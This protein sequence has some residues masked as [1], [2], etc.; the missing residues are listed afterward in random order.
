MLQNTTKDHSADVYKLE[1]HLGHIHQIIFAP[2]IAA[3]TD[4]INLSIYGSTISLQQQAQPY[5]YSYTPYNIQ[6]SQPNSTGNF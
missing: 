4:S 1:T 5:P 6:S 3:D 2:P